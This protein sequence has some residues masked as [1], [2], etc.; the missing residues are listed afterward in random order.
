MDTK[1]VVSFGEILWDMLPDRTVLGGAPFNF[2]YRITSLGDRGVIMSRLGHDDRGVRAHETVRSLG[3]ETAAI[4]W[5][6]AFPT[7]TV[8]VNF[9]DNGN[10]DFVITPRVAYDYIELTDQYLDCAAAAD[11][12]CFGTLIQRN[13]QSRATL[14]ALL[15]RFPEPL[16]FL[17]INLRKECYTKGT[18]TFSLEQADM[19]KLNED[20]TYRLADILGTTHEGIPGF[21][22]TMIQMWDLRYCVVTLGERGAYAEADSGAHVYVPG[23]RIDCADS[24]GSGDAFSAVFVHEILHG[25]GLQNACERGNILGALVATKPGATCTVTGE[26]LAAFSSRDV[27]RNVHPDLADLLEER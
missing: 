24:V 13:D 4:Q 21:C 27:P 5:D 16:R 19:L 20:E 12:I 7:G 3:L 17:D 1:T 15:E 14:A 23:Y 10:P 22:S 9:D 6:D 26:E 11:C 8:R 25:A 18:I 2:A